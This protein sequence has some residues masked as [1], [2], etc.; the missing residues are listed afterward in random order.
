MAHRIF[1]GAGFG[2]AGMRT[3]ASNLVRTLPAIAVDVMAPDLDTSAHEM[4]GLIA[5][6]HF[7][8]AICQ[9]PIGAAL[10]RFSIRTA[11]LALFGGTVAGSMLA[12][13][14]SGPL[15]VLIAQRYRTLL[16]RAN[17]GLLRRH[18]PDRARCVDVCTSADLRDDPSKGRGRGYRQG[19]LGD[20]S[21]VLCRDCHDA[22][23]NRSHRRTTGIDGHVAFHGRGAVLVNTLAFL[24]LT[25]AKR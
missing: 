1:S 15:S 20:Q 21:R 18:L 25:P 8:F 22:I 12:A 2:R 23:L 11:S 7:A 24:L 16:R 3:H 19:S 5:V 17:A 6:Y 10:D 14:L 13:L 9:L 4:A